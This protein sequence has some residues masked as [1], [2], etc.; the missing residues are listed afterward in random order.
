MSLTDVLELNKTE[1]FAKIRNGLP[2]VQ[3]TQNLLDCK[4]DL[5]FAWHAKDSCLL[6][7]NW[8]SSLAA[9]VNVQFQ[10]LIPSCFVSLEVDRV[11]ASNEGSLVALSGPRG[12]VI[13]ELPRRWGPDGYYKEG[14]P[15]IT[16]HSFGLDTQLFLKNPHLEVRQVRWHPHSVSDSTLIVLLNNNTIRVYNHSKLRHVWQVGPTVLRSGANN[17]LCDFGEVA[18]DFDI[19]PAAKP[20][21][22]EPETAGN[23]ETTLD[24][25]NK[26]LVA[27]KSLPKQERIEWPIVLLRENGNIYILMTA[28]DSEN[29]RLQGPITITPQAHDN[30]GLESCALMI[31]P[32]L[33]PTLVIAESNGKLHHALL[34]EADATEKSFSEVDDFVL[35]EPAE[36]VVHV[37]E[38]VKLELGISASGT[39]KGGDNCP[40]YLK[41]DLINELRYFAYHNAGLHA[42]TVSFIAELQ[43]YLESESDEDRLELAASASAEYILCTKFDSSETVNAVFGLALLQIPAGMVL[44]LGSGQVI[45]LKLV[46]DA[47]LLVTPNE[48]K[49]VDPEVSQQE[50]GP[51]FVDTI[52]SLLQRSVNQP[53]LADKLSSPSAQESY[54]LLNQAIEVLREQY[55]KRHDLVRAAFTRH[56]NQIQLK[57]E[58]QLQEIQNLEQ[59]RELISERAHKLAERFEEI[60]YNQE[61]LVRKC[62]ALMQRANASLP[63]NVIAERQFSQEVYRL[64]KVTQSLAA[65]L[66]SVKK[67]FNKQR[68]HISKTQDDLKKNAY[69]L[70]EK[71]HRT[72]TEILTQLTEEIQR[73]ITDVKRI[74]KI[75]GI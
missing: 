40:I 26:T 14:K 53:I 64:N 16:C 10:T 18:V 50:S 22:T 65:G 43:R 41:R 5:L 70:P 46:I 23:N 20:R 33:P 12:V 2:V 34:M 47:Q 25:S 3:R 69:E 74:N 17:S 71:Q 35:I 49:P 45:S 68:Y 57:K 67:T 72:I 52:K 21:V 59:E 56:I 62:N 15:V 8:R 75:V 32:S 44:L 7:R 36:Y 60:S 61:L 42:I 37:L 31:I 38:T 9:K 29:T 1:M 51:A 54:E 19:A 39:E 11:L 24:K 48:N 73:Q 66:D 28:V 63:N 27:A 30:Y 58:Q 6:V 4:D 13:M 55:L